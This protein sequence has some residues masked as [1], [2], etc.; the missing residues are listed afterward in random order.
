MLTCPMCG[1]LVERFKS[2]SHI[3]P[4]GILKR[5]KTGGRNVKID[6]KDKKVAINQSD[7]RSEFWCESCE[8]ESALDDAYGIDVLVHRKQGT[9]NT[10]RT[11]RGVR[12]KVLE[13]LDYVRFKKFALSIPI[14]E[15]LARQSAQREHLMTVGSQHLWTPVIHQHSP[16]G[17]RDDAELITSPCAVQRERRA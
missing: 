2:G 15:Q 13:G 5:T 3:M 16:R 11:Q 14:R 12:F 8:R 10:T 17:A 6:L 7:E 9:L 4:R 1:S